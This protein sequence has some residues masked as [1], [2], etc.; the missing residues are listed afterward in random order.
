MMPTRARSQ[1]RST[2]AVGSIWTLNRMSPYPPSFRRTPARITEP[3]VGA[4]TWASGSQVCNGHV[5]SFVPKAMSRPTKARSATAPGGTGTLAMIAV[6]S[7]VCGL[8]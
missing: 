6:M 5:G 7:N 2:A 8:E 1:Y 3:P 4:S